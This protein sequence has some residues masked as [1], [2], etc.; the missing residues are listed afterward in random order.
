MSLAN[1]KNL[2]QSLEENSGRFPNR[3]SI[4]Y[5][6]LVY[7]YESLNE[8]VNKAGNA[9]LNLG[10][11]KGDRVIISLLNGPEFV[12]SFYALAK[13]G[14]IAVP[15][16]YLLTKNEEKYVWEDS[17][18]GL[19]IT[20][21]NKFP[22]FH[23]MTAGAVPILVVG[24]KEEET[25]LSGAL[26]FWGQIKNEPDR[27]SPCPCTQEEVVHIL[28]T[29]GTTGKPKGAMLTHYSVM[30]CSS[31]Y[32]DNDNMGEIFSQESRV[33][34]ALPLYHCYGQ[35]VCLITPLS[36]GATVILVDRFNTEKVLRAITEHHATIFAGVPTMYAYLTGGFD[37]G[38]HNLQSLKF[39]CSAGAALSSEI[40]KG[41]REKTGVE[42]I[43]GYGIT[44]ASAQ[45]IAPPFRPDK[46]RH[47]KFG[48][49][50]IPL[51]NSKRE[52]EVKIVDENGEEL[53][54]NKVGE[55]VI[56]GDHVM[57]GYWKLP[58]ETEKTIRQGW[59]HTG[60]LAKMDEDGYFYIVDRKKD[61][62]IVGGENVYPREIE[63]VLYQ[64]EKILEVAVVGYLDQVKGEAVKAVVVLKDN[65]QATERELI[66]FC[67]QR[68]AKFKIPR[69]IEFKKELPKSATGKILRRLVK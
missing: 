56:K 54:P 48:S 58:E 20:D 64:N 21:T 49:I 11:R 35:N 22:E 42:I 15:I 47:D 24:Q 13:I 17:E 37:P 53:P 7:T 52:T 5:E 62:I 43:E 23:E 63:E 41:F 40:A 60:D 4:I 61:M 18:A 45:A 34:C 6:Q 57:K 1:I 8:L 19:I 69:I 38:R 3:T 39:C 59:L 66:D 46:R 44:E 28:Y 9:F 30:Y 25:A 12:I 67:A 51:K 10:I 55:L 32:T 68:L 2:A 14:A 29:S 31:L 36:V 65:L 33:V 26:K 27:L 16:N 50:G